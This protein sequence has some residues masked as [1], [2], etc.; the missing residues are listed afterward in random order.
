MLNKKLS[1]LVVLMATLSGCIHSPFGKKDS[2]KEKSAKSKRGKF[3]KEGGTYVFSDD[4][5]EFRLE[6]DAQDVFDGGG[7]YVGDRDDFQWDNIVYDTDA[8][9]VIQFDF[10]DPSIKKSE[11]PK[12]KHNADLAKQEL[13]SNP[14]T[15]VAV[16]GHSCKI[17]KSDLYNRTISQERAENVAKEYAKRGVPRSKVKPIGFGASELL[18]D[19]DGRESQA[20]N[21]RVETDFVSNLVK[22]I[23]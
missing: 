9:E 8:G 21:R 18:T 10:D 6:E 22:E 13:D 19:E 1:L 17:A 11:L 2:K 12:I 3:I 20:V 14:N 23:E 15:E 4:A 5:D 16:K 7:E